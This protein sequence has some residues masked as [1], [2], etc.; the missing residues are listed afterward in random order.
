MG[1][2]NGPKR[3]WWQR[4]QITCVGLQGRTYWGIVPFRKIWCWRDIFSMPVRYS[5]ALDLWIGLWKLRWNWRNISLLG[6]RP[7]QRWCDSWSSLL[8]ASWTVGFSHCTRLHEIS[9]NAFPHQF[10]MDLY[11]VETHWHHFCGINRCIFDDLCTIL[12]NQH[13]PWGWTG[14]V[15]FSVI[16]LTNS[17]T[18]NSGKKCYSGK[19]CN[20]TK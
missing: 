12:K 16:G 6:P 13:I 15:A 7:K 2:D 11:R 17:L 5:H 3:K 1:C 14:I 9:R 18:A 20:L 8:S 4:W 10:S 19:N